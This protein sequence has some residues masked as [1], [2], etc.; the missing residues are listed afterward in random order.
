[1]EEIIVT[2]IKQSNEE[3]DIAIPN[4]VKAEQVI[5]AILHHEKIDE[6]LSGIYEIRIT[7]DKEEWHSIRNDETLRDNDVWDGQ[8]IML[9]KKGAIIPSFEMLPA[10]D[11]HNESVI[12]DVPSDKEEGYVWKIIE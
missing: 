6:T 12:P 7:K 8:Y 11:Q 10:K 3:I 4:D 9:H 2:Y 1:M 5:E